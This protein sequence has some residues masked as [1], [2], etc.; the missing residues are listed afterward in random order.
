M[1]PCEIRYASRAE[2]ERVDE[3]RAM[4]HALHAAGRPDLFRPEFSKALQRHVYEQF[5]SDCA[6][7]IV[8]LSDGTICGY[9]IAEYVERPQ[10]AYNLA[11]RY[12]HIEEFG[13]D[14]AYQRR[15]QCSPS[16]SRRPRAG[17]FRASI[18]ICSPSMKTPSRFTKP[19]TCVP[20]GA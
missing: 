12:Y 10:S 20:T 2:L 16:A 15:G 4:V 18:W 9:V 7:V 6:N 14:A 8:A 19:W 5:S 1:I 13:V 17:A 11:R 3:L